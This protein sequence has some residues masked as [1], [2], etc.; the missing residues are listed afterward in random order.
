MRLGVLLRMGLSGV[1]LV[2]G[3][4][5]MILTGAGQAGAAPPTAP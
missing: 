5:G 1:L 2:G 4:A 3:G